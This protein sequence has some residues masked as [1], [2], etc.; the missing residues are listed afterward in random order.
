M[1]R[2]H[3]RGTAPPPRS[4]DFKIISVKP[5]FAAPCFGLTSSNGPDSSRSSTT[6]ANASP[7]PQQRGWHGEIQGLQSSLASAEAKLAGLDRQRQTQLGMPK[8]DPTQ[9]DPPAVAP[10]GRRHTLPCS[11]ADSACPLPAPDPTPSARRGQEALN[12]PLPQLS[13]RT[14]AVRSHEVRGTRRRTT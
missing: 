14:T 5:V 3:S 11:Q 1:V 10:N 2:G 9:A 4:R 12:A 7:R 8:S 6:S 13:D